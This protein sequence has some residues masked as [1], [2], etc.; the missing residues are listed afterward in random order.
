MSEPGSVLMAGT[1][2]VNLPAILNSI[3]G[4]AAVGALF[5]ALVYFTTTQELPLWNRLTFFMT[6]FVM[7][8]LFTPAIVDFE[9]YGMRPFA[10]SGPAGFAG[11]GLVVTIML[12]AIKRRGAPPGA[13]ARGGNDD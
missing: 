13:E 6:S 12:A 8:Y 7:G 5:G 11:A 9:F 4:E 3:N 1:L 10:Y 2:G